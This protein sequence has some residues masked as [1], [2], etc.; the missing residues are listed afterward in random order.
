MLLMN[1]CLND[2]I[3]LKLHINFTYLMIGLTI[4]F[5]KGCSYIMRLIAFLLFYYKVLA[6]IFYFGYYL[7]YEYT[8]KISHSLSKEIHAIHLK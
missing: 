2:Y 1:L 6:D 8:L 4:R 7:F 3:T 5:I